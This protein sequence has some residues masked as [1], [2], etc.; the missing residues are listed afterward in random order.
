MEIPGTAPLKEARLRLTTEAGAHIFL[1]EEPG[2]GRLFR[3]SR[4]LAATFLRAR[5]VLTGA[6]PA[7]A[8]AKAEVAALAAH[9]TGLRG[10]AVGG[11]KAFNPLFMMIPLF[12]ARPLQAPVAGLARALFS[13]GGLALFILLALLAIWLGAASGFVFVDHIGDI[14]S[15]SALATFALIA[16]F[17][18]LAHESG[19]LL[20]ATRF[21]VPVRNAGIMLIALFPLPFVDCTEAEFRATR[22]GRIVISLA[23]LL[24]DLAIGL[25]AFILWHFASDD[26]TRQLLSNIV[27]LNTATTLIF[28]LNPLMRLDGY[29][30]L[31]DALH[32]RNLHME[33]ALALA[34]A[35]RAAA[36]LE[37][38]RLRAAIADAPGRIAF[39]LM[40]FA[41]KI[42]ILIF[43]AW[44]IA[45]KYLGVGLAVVVWGAAAMFLSP[46]M[47]PPRPEAD[48]R[49]GGARRWRW[50]GAILLVLAGLA[51]MPLRYQTVIPVALDLE[52]AYTIRAAAEGNLTSI[53]PAGTVADGERLAEAGNIETAVEI[54]LND[55]DQAMLGYLADSVR[56]ENPLAAQNAQ[57]RIESAK[58]LGVDLAEEQAAL[59]VAADQSGWFRPDDAARIGARLRVGQPVGVLLPEAEESALTGLLPE[60]YARKFRE[61]LTRLELWEPQTGE[62]GPAI[63]ARMAQSAIDKDGG[64]AFR[65]SLRASGAPVSY[66]GRATQLKLT[67]S[68]E[69]LWRHAVFLGERLRLAFLRNRAAETR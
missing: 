18:K 46:L 52:G 1:L 67:F 16:P 51:F 59:I 10:G 6:R 19:H 33:S 61:D 13:R 40:A 32:R 58:A 14:F 15:L 2:G 60:L 20:A 41:Y 28:N 53:R 68:A 31:S 62:T 65:I 38:G 8:E 36:G 26:F 5:Q 17:L 44:T 64:G 66:A 22:L 11:K 48:A 29:F 55:A 34:A 39:G 54:A 12:D 30:A 45:P 24:A 43:I 27:I 21:G 50:L 37:F 7:T 47:K 57:E 69:P 49:A 56:A 35:R 25:V 9:L 42:Y 23:G 4:A 3:M 63:D